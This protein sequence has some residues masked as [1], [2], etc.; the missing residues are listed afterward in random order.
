MRWFVRALSPDYVET[1][2]MWYCPAAEG[3]NST[4]ETDWPKLNKNPRPPALRFA[5]SYNWQTWRRKLDRPPQGMFR[6][7]IGFRKLLAH[8][9]IFRHPQ[10]EYQLYPNHLSRGSEEYSDGQM[11]LWTDGSVE[12]AWGWVISTAAGWES[13]CS[14]YFTCEHDYDTRNATGHWWF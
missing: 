7:I 2:E 3:K 13:D 14:R 9:H 6:N 1:P 4:F 5:Q 8:D 11:Q 12:W 10:L